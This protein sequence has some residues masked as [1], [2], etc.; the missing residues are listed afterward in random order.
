MMAVF[1]SETYLRPVQRLVHTY[2]KDILSVIC[3]ALL[4]GVIGCATANDR[5]PT[6]VVRADPEYPRDLMYRGIKGEADVEFTVD[7]DGSVR[8]VRVIH[9][10]R[11]E[12]GEAAAAC[13][14]KWK[15]TPGIKQGVPVA[16]RLRQSFFFSVSDE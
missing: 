11:P 14:L 10:T 7:S 4:V 1:C 13:M 9:A 5:P 16:A 8:D 2:M 12:F 3:L 6:N 15:F